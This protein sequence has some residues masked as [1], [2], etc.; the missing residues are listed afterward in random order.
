MG[1]QR[2]QQAPTNVSSRAR[3]QDEPGPIDRIASAFDLSH[4]PAPIRAN[5]DARAGDDRQLSKMC[6]G[7]ACQPLPLE[8]ESIKAEPLPA[9][10]GVLQ[11]P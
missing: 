9:P 11:K 5:R 2:P 7:R 3:Q 8:A 10:K 6:A 1:D 4:L